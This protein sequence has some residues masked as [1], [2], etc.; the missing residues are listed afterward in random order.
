MWGVAE[1]GGGWGV[2]K[3]GWQ[4]G[5]MGRVSLSWMGV[6]WGWWLSRGQYVSRQCGLVWEGRVAGS[7][8][9]CGVGGLG[10]PGAQWGITGL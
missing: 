9:D 3:G 2:Q 10:W 6:A 4:V 5:G 8:C 7:G 1:L